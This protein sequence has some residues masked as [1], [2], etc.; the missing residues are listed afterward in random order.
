MRRTSPEDTL[1]EKL[2]G[3][4]FH[5]RQAALAPQGL[6]EKAAD[7]GLEQVGAEIDQDDVQRRPLGIE[8]GPEQPRALEAIDLRPRQSRNPSKSATPAGSPSRSERPMYAKTS[9]FSRMNSEIFAL[10]RPESSATERWSNRSPNA[11]PTRP[12][13]KSS[14]AR[15]RP[16]FERKWCCTRPGETRAARATSRMEVAE[17]PRAANSRSAASRSAPPP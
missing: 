5:A 11:S 1:H 6:T 2:H 14:T 4:P 13:T 16:A 8:I 10:I 15:R 17:T 12:A 9:G 3:G 7:A